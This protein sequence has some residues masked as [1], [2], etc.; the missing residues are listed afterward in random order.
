[1]ATISISKFACNIQLIK[2][3]LHLLFYFPHLLFCPLDS[4][5]ITD[6]L[7]GAVR[8][9]EDKYT[10]GNLFIKP[11]FQPIT[12]LCFSLRYM[13]K[14][15]YITDNSCTV[16]RVSEQICFLLVFVTHLFPLY[17]LKANYV[18]FL[19]S[20]PLSVNKKQPTQ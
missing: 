7:F 17:L 19:F 9:K 6:F 5:L 16:P 18:S 12:Y 20:F 2:T 13:W 3:C 15:L 4:L 10:V 11:K 8:K 14:G 1:M